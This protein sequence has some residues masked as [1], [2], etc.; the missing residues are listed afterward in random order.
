MVTQEILAAT[1][2]GFPVLS[3]LIWLPLVVAALVGLCPT[4]RLAYR[5]AVLGA[6]TELALAVWLL[7]EF[8][9]GSQPGWRR[10]FL[11]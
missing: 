7:G 5:V 9:P 8:I 1:Q 2:V 11:G 6:L 10:G 3:V 4:P